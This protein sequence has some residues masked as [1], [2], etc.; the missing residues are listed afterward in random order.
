MVRRLIYERGSALTQLLMAMRNWA[1]FLYH[2]LPE[3]YVTNAQY[4][5]GGVACVPV[6]LPIP[7]FVGQLTL[8]L[9]RVLARLVFQG[10]HGNGC[11]SR[12]G[13]VVN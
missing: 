10:F 12:V 8:A 13:A 4:G 2:C 11:G 1:F 9:G 7:C 6:L 5:A 3:L